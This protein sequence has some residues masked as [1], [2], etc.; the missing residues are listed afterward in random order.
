MR[1][2]AKAGGGH[3]A[4]TM[5]PF[6]PKL[7][8]VLAAIVVS[9]HAHAGYAN[10]SPPM[11]WGGNSS[12]GWTYSRTAANS[13]W[14]GGSAAAQVTQ[15]V[16]GR[17][18]TMPAS[19]RMAANAGKYVAAAARITPG[20]IVTAAVA[21]W[22]LTEGIQWVDGQW[23]KAG[24]P[25]PYPAGF[26]VCGTGGINCGP[27]E[28]QF[29]ELKAGVQALYPGQT[30]TNCAL[31]FPEAGLRRV[32]CYLPA[33]DAY[34]AFQASYT[35][36]PG[37]QVVH[38][39]GVC[40][41]LTGTPPS[42]PTS[43]ATDTDWSR[44][45]TKPVPDQVAN[46]TP[47]PLPVELPQ[48]NP[49]STGLPQPVTVPTGDPVPVPETSPQQ[50]K[51]PVTDVVPSPTQTEPWRVDLRPREV[52]GTDPAG[53]TQPTGTSTQP[54]TAAEELITCGLPGKPKCLIDEQDTPT[55][56]TANEAPA[57]QPSAQVDAA[58]QDIKDI[59]ADP[60]GK[61]GGFPEIN[62][63]FQLP[64]FC[65]PISL[66]AF[67]PYLSEINVCQFQDTFHD[68]MGVVWLLGGLFGAISIFWRDQLLTP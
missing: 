48:I 1:S 5:Q 51:Q 32:T 2:M 29:D 43:P 45:D 56:T 31:T 25:W 63:A 23:H 37:G 62:W 47:G 9:G 14:S 28:P 65:G 11:G 17:A 20:G 34:A 40:R 41:A 35:A 67:E 18:V 53:V 10:P 7:L 27:L 66:P 19:M 4:S 8:A 52:I 33:A 36:C 46:D 30:F 3:R 60:V 42:A 39:D 49:D 16:G 44:F 22:L 54:G 64:T 59:I 55:P 21:T 24:A 15:N 38:P 12:S 13:A 50:Y 68:I 26:W 6:V 57:P 61:L 58:T